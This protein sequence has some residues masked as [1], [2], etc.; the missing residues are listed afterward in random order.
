[1]WERYSV[2]GVA[3]AL[4]II[5][6][7]FHLLRKRKIQG[8]AF[9][10][11]FIVGVVLCLFSTVPV[12]FELLAMLYGTQEMVSAVT[13]TGFLFFL[14]VF[15]YLHSRISELH[16]LLMK[17]TMEISLIKYDQRQMGRSS[18]R[19]KSEKIERWKNED[20]RETSGSRRRTSV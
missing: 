12:L 19:V 20:E 18:T 17:L 7:D 6:L 16:S 14:L 5:L 2:I 15:L 3:F 4:T 1:L 8:K 11:W 9:V 13:A 10:F